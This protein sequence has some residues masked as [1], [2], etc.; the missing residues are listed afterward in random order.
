MITEHVDLDRHHCG[1]LSVLEFEKLPFVPRRVFWVTDVPQGEERGN[2]AHVK[3][4][5]ILVCL[6]GRIVV[7][8]DRGDGPKESVLKVGEHV[9]VGRMTW[10]SQVFMTGKDVLFAVCSTKYDKDDYIDDKEVFYT[11]LK[12]SVPLGGID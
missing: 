5:Q 2:H 7:R 9:Y 10:D 3:T 8:L 12:K 11:M 6:R 1:I 4:E